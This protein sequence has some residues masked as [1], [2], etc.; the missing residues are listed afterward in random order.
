M[1]GWVCL[2]GGVWAVFDWCGVNDQQLVD[3]F[4]CLGEAAIV[5]CATIGG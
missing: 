4:D 3:D 1:G 5:G 2:V